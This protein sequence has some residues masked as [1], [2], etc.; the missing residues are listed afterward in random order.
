MS[1]YVSLMSCLPVVRT[2]DELTLNLAVTIVPSYSGGD[3]CIRKDN[4]QCEDG[5]AVDR[6]TEQ[7]LDTHD[8][9]IEVL[10]SSHLVACATPILIAIHSTSYVTLTGDLDRWTSTYV[11]VRPQINRTG[12]SGDLTRRGKTF[13][14]QTLLIPIRSSLDIF[15]EIACSGKE[16]PR[17]RKMNTHS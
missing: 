14:T 5:T 17:L 13:I 8:D 12:K 16:S 1:I 7:L 6:K 11:S 4:K 15:I 10:A 2:K 9:L 3:R